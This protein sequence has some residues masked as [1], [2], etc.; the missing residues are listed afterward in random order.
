VADAVSAFE[1]KVMVVLGGG[2]GPRG[3]VA[4]VPTITG[5]NGAVGAL[6]GEVD[7]ADAT[8]TSA[9]QNAMTQTEAR[10]ST[11]MKQWTELKQTDLSALNQQL[12]GANLPALRLESAMPD[13]DESE[14]VE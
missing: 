2:E 4:A 1:K 13:T 8:P 10:F 9:Q 12:R 6:Y 7:R 5:V 3:A 11:V 14:D